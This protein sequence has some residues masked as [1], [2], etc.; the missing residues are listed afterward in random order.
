[1]KSI[2]YILQSTTSQQFRIE[3]DIFDMT[4]GLIYR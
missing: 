3:A 4:P 1:M 2:L